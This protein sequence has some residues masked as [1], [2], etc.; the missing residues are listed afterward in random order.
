[1]GKIKCVAMIPARMGSK[2]IPKKNIRL[3]QGK[4]LVQYAMDLALG[5]GCFGE[6]WL[7]SES[8]LL[9]ELARRRGVLFHKRPAALSSDSATND[10][11][12][13]EFLEGHACD[14][15]V[16]VNPTS[17]LV[18]PETLVSFSDFARNGAHDTVFSVE[19]EYAECFLHDAPLNFSLEKKENSQDLPPVR[20]V[21]W[22]LTSWRKETFLRAVREGRCGTYA[23]RIGLFSIPKTE[24]CDIDTPEDWALAEGMLR[25]RSQGRQPAEYWSE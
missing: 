11:F 15:L 14:M 16:M 10:E 7:N 17:P 5:S 21:V 20:K 4:P 13:A 22:A 25:A 9:G 1:M 3:L 23:G 24:A 2:R 12:I 6:I 19:D 18:R 8:E